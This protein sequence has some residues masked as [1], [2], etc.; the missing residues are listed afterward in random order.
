MLSPTAAARNWVWKSFLRG[1][2]PVLMENI[3][4][5]STGRAV[6]T[7]AGDSGFMAARAAIGHTRRYANKMNLITMMPRPDLA[8]T[9][10]ALAR[11]GS[12]YLVYQPQP[13]PFHRDV[14]QGTYSYEWFN[15]VSGAVVTPATSL[16]TTVRAL[17]RSIYR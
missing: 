8:S 13:H 3:F 15:A 7:T 6:P 11:P 10:Y 1:H 14:T 12:E 5:N 4:Q 16:S 17:L 9:R 2:N